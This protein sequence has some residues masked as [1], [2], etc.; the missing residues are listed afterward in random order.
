MTQPLRRRIRQKRI[1]TCKAELA[2][3]PQ[4]LLALG[5]KMADIES[6]P[7]VDLKREFPEAYIALL[8]QRD[9]LARYAEDL[10]DE[11][12]VLGT[13]ERD[14]HSTRLELQAQRAIA[15][16]GL[17]KVRETLTPDLGTIADFSRHTSEIRRAENKLRIINRMLMSIV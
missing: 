3:Y 16:L 7:T 12:E 8:D 13:E 5:Q 11:L 10:R 9:E 17:E 14:L 1:E 4:R 6:I 2:L 15:I